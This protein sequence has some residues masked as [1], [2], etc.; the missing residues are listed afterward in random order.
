MR[1]FALLCLAVFVFSG[2]TRKPDPV[3]YR[4]EMRAFVEGISAKGRGLRPRFIVIPQNGEQLLTVTGTADGAA[5]MDYVNAIDGVGREDLNFGYDGDDLPTTEADRAPMLGLLQRAH[6]VGLRVMVTDYCSSITN[7]DS[8]YARNYR[9]DFIGFAADRRELN[10]I[11]GYPAAPYNSNSDSIK[12]MSYAKNFLYIINP[13]AFETREG[14]LAA[15]ASTN[16]DVVVMDLNF[17]D[18]SV[19]TSAEI[20]A[21][22][23]KPGGG[24]RKIIC[25]LSIGEA[26]TYRYYWQPFWTSNPPPFIVAEN[27][28]WAGNVKVK[29]WDATW[30]GIIYKNNNSYLNRIMDAGFDGVYLDI[31]DGFEYFEEIYSR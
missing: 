24:T 18:G 12:A 23:N 4:K 1:Q 17:N 8:A 16:Y 26:E 14:Y 21:L 3:D 19:F 13:D 28:S 10:N 30:Q 2:C 5:D 25:Y 29:Y 20:Q 15:I 6:D 27:A 22:K 31:I 7:I 9:H 11:P